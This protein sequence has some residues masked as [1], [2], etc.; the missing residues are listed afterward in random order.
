M[1]VYIV[2][3]KQT[4]CSSQKAKLLQRFNVF[5]IIFDEFLK[6]VTSVFFFYSLLT[7]I[8]DFEKYT[9]HTYFE[10]LYMYIYIG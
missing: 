1:T 5:I 6:C 10:S 4:L 3:Y 9:F 7:M 8:L 2:L